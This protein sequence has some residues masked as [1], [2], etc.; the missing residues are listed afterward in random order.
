[1]QTYEGYWEN[2]SFHHYMGNSIQTSGRRRAFVTILDEHV[3]PPKHSDD[4]AFWAEFDRMTAESA[5]ENDLLLDEAFARRPSGR[6]LVLFDDEVD[7]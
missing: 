3:K 5:A 1:M 7:E 6:E 4:R 2:G